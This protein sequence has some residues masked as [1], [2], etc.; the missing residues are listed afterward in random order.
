MTKKLFPLMLHHFHDNKKHFKTQQKTK[1]RSISNKYCKHANE[2]K[3]QD[4]HD[5]TK[6]C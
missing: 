3:R 1:K 6:L 5:E 2:R 4:K